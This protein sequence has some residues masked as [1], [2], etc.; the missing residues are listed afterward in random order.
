MFVSP[1]HHLFCLS[2][3]ST[4]TAAPQRICCCSNSW[5]TQ[6]PFRAGKA[7]Q[8][9]S[10]VEGIHQPGVPGPFRLGLL[11]TGPD[12]K[13]TA[14]KREVSCCSGGSCSTFVCAC[15]A[16]KPWISSWYCCTWRNAI[17]KELLQQPMGVLFSGGTKIS[18]CYL[19]QRW[20]IF[21]WATGSGTDAP[22]DL[23]L[24]LAMSFRMAFCSKFPASGITSFQLE[25]QLFSDIW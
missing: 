24:V 21:I 7:E 1:P 23:C 14:A 19:D 25:K 18:D 22:A 9:I 8:S 4:S 17:I 5:M 20:W 13:I 6:S 11:S 2:L 10:G 16:G 12:S 15:L 3:L